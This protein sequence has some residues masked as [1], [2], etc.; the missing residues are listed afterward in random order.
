MCAELKVCVDRD[1][2]ETVVG[3]SGWREMKL[4]WTSL[5]RWDEL[6]E[7]CLC[8]QTS[9]YRACLAIVIKPQPH[10]WE[11]IYHCV[12]RIYIYFPEWKATYYSFW[13][14][15]KWDSACFTP[16]YGQSFERWACSAPISVYT[17][18]QHRPT[19]SCWPRRNVIF[20]NCFQNHSGLCLLAFCGSIWRVVYLP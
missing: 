13:V 1:F 16:P 20:W 18:V 11:T 17:H 19:T 7:V 6:T 2:H 5:C 4:A 8:F 3:K 10:W 9:W 15:M 14:G 12:W